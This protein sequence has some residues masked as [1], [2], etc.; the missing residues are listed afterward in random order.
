VTRRVLELSGPI[1]TARLLLRTYEARDFA[2]LHDLFGREDVCR[3]LLWEPMNAE[4]AHA[5]LEQRLVQR[6]LETDGDAL[7]L[8]GVDAAT[9]RPIGEFMLGMTS[10]RSRQGEIGWSLHP[11]AQGRGLATEGARE[12]LRLGFGELRL[13]RI[14]AA[15]DPRNAA[16]LRV[17]ERLA[18]RREADFVENELLKGEWV[19]ETVCA[20]LASEWRERAVGAGRSAE[21]TYPASA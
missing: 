3:Y 4:Q 21:T 15:C 7:M 11:D 10:A 17:M 13:H 2:F 19:G 12:L 6:R 16:S 14:V 9:G 1:S 20:L 18:M 5:K 8:V